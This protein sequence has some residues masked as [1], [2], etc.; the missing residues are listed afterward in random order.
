MV[1]TPELIT[2]HELLSASE[3]KKAIKRYG[4]P[5][6]KFPKILESDPQAKKLGARPGNLIAVH[7]NDPTG[8]Y[9]Y[10]R[11]VVKG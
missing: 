10:Y 5:L 3:A 6:E 8:S 1:K 7:R 9:I 4:T 11:L 2:E